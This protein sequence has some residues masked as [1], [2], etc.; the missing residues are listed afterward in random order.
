MYNHVSLDD[1]LGG[2][3]PENNQEHGGYLDNGVAIQVPSGPVTVPGGTASINLPIG[4]DRY[5]SH[6]SGTK[7]GINI[8][9]NPNQIG[10][11]PM[12]FFIQRPDPTHFERI[13]N[14]TGYVFGRGDNTVYIY[15][16]NGIQASMHT[17][18]F[19]N[20]LRIK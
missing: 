10:A 8:N 11:T 15:N 12:S 20:L 17:D 19:I 5:H 7:G 3:R 13:G 6:P 4:Y 1:G 14:N 16:K 9:A 18:N 2:T